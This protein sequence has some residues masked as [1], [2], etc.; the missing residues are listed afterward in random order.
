MDH[1]PDRGRWDAVAVV[2]DLARQDRPLSADTWRAEPRREDSNP[3][4]SNASD[5]GHRR[6]PGSLLQDAWRPKDDVGDARRSSWS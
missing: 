3:P 2:A 4:R 5:P 1:S 6:G